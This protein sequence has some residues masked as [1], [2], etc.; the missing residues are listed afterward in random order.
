MSIIFLIISLLM[1]LFK[2][3]RYIYVL[4]SLEF[5]MMSVFVKFYFF[6]GGVYFFFLLCHSVIS[7][8]LGVVVM[9]SSIKFFG[10][11]MCIYYSLKL[12]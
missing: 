6:W 2:W 5:M 3:Q 11:D 8:I 7:S 9:V 1:M 12:S 4:I 10:S